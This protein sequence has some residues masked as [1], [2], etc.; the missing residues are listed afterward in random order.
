MLGRG[1]V[2]GVDGTAAY[3]TS[4]LTPGDHTIEAVYNGDP[5]FAGSTSPPLPQN[6]RQP[7]VSVVAKLTA[8]KVTKAGNKS[9]ILKVAYNSSKAIRLK[10]IDIK[11]IAVTGPV[12]IRLMA[13][14]CTPSRDAAKLTASYQI[15]PKSGAWH[16]SDSGI[17]TVT[18]KARQVSTSSGVWNAADTLGTFQVA[19]PGSR[20]IRVDSVTPV[21]A[22]SAPLIWISGRPS[23]ST[24]LSSRSGILE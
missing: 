17:Y 23:G 21:K 14:S 6:V 16:A 10:T 13:V 15:I 9:L 5:N 18:L 22:Q 2:V 3:S 11:D 7:A 4:G 24:W 1:V 8:G 20:L 12:A 19:I